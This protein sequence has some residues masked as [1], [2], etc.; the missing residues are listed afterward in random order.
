MNSND[1]FWC[2]LNGLIENID[3]NI[4]KCS[5]KYKDK[6]EVDHLYSNLTVSLK[7]KLVIY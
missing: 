2:K 7:K 1:Y 5:K 6:N 3:I 4:K